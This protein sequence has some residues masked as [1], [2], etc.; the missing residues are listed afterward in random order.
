MTGFSASVV[1]P[2]YNK[3]AFIRATLQSALAQSHPATEIIIVDD[4]STDGSVA[5]I[6]DLIGGTPLGGSVRLI[7]QA[8]AGPGPARNRGVAEASGEWVAFLDADDLWQPN[9]LA[10]LAEVAAQCPDA[11]IVAARHQRV[12]ATDPLSAPDTSPLAARRIDYFGEAQAGEIL[13]STSVAVRRA[14]LIEAGGF[15]AFYP[16][17]DFELWTRLA[18]DHVI[19]VSARTTAFY[20]QQTGGLMEQHELGDSGTADLQP[21]FRTL[22]RAIH[23]PRHAGQRQRLEQYRA[24]LL[25]RTV[26]QA[27]Y[28]GAP[29]EARRAAAELRAQ[30]GGGGLGWLALLTWLP[31]P[32]LKAGRVARG[33]WRGQSSRRATD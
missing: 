30:G 14:V 12:A 4:H 31:A 8:N 33:G 11:T 19:A 7:E 26:R 21:V 1:I 17:E 23:D 3:R 27:I 20:V 10:T 16:G 6:A 15:G 22:H 13:S 5:A 25:R 29:R 2:L 9:H 18:L 32:L 24:F 28:R